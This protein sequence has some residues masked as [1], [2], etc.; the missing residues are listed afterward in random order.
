MKEA[1]RGN[2]KSFYWET[3]DELEAHLREEPIQNATILI[4]GSRGMS[5][6]TLLDLL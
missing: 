4:K 1:T 5:L 3:K 2:G 6:E